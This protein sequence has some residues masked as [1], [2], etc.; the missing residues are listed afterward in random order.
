MRMC[1]GGGARI[2]KKTKLKKKKKTVIP[3]HLLATQKPLPPTVSSQ[4]PFIPLS[5][6]CIATK[7]QKLGSCVDDRVTNLF[8]AT[9]CTGRLY[10]SAAERGELNMDMQRWLSLC[11]SMEQQCPAI[12]PG[13]IHTFHMGQMPQPDVGV[14]LIQHRQLTHKVTSTFIIA[15]KALFGLAAMF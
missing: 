6:A 13:I 8:G 10:S 5:P 1:G 9:H 4:T 11:T 3:L 14:R 15:G 7:A 2:K 12:T